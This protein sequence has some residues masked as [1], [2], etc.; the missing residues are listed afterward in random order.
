MTLFELSHVAGQC[1]DSVFRDGV[2]DRGPNATFG[3]VSFQAQ[4]ALLGGAV[5]KY[6]FKRLVAEPKRNI[7]M[8]AIGMRYVVDIETAAVDLV[9]KDVLLAEIRK[10]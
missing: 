7:H 9:V 6:L 2:V 8:G 10:R 4:K 3:P 1:R 5:E